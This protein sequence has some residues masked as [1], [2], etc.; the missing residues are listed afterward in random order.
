MMTEQF[1]TLLFPQRIERDVQKI[2]STRDSEAYRGLTNALKKLPNGASFFL[3]INRE[4]GFM[5]DIDEDYNMMLIYPQIAIYL[6][7]HYEEIKKLRYLIV[8]GSGIH[9]CRR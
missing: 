2:S 1:V 3:I 5:T 4:D 9:R 8:D 6:A 7:I